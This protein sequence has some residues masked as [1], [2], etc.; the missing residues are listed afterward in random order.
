MIKSFAGF[1]FVVCSFFLIIACNRS[2]AKKTPNVNHINVNLNWQRFEKDFYQ[3]DTNNIQPGLAAL[4]QKYGSFVYEYAVLILGLNPSDSAKLGLFFKDNIAFDKIL[5]DSVPGYVG[6]IDAK[7]DAIKKAFQYI[8][9]YFPNA[10]LP[11]NIYTYIAEPNTPAVALLP[12][13]MAIGLHAFANNFPLYQSPDFVMDFPQY[14]TRRFKQE[15]MENKIVRAILEKDIYPSYRKPGPLI[16]Q[17]VEHGK[18]WWLT[19]K[20]LPLQHD[21]ITTGFT[22]FQLKGCL[23]NEGLI[24]NNISNETDPYSQDVDVV[25]M[26]LGDGPKTDFMGEGS[27]GNIGQWV[28]MRIVQK[29]ESKN[30]NKSVEEIL[31]TPAADLIKAANYNPR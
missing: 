6:N 28:G 18:I 13:G 12:S 3:L 2:N 15:Y 29:F 25:R 7:P 17:L 5:Y 20:I 4:Q 8:K 19:Q 9:Y 14:V 11:Q 16:E 26:Y 23:K 10:N 22:H 1:S 21:T 30:I 27:P 31:K 24:W